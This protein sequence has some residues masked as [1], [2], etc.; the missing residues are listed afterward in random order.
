M[1]GWM[2]V[3]KIEL[4][5]RGTYYVERKIYDAWLVESCR[6]HDGRVAML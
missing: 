6:E 3:C 4:F 2:I 5:D 1:N